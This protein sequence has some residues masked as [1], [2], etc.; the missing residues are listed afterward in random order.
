MTETVE[1]VRHGSIVYTDKWKGYDSLMFC[2]I[3]TSVLIIHTNSSQG[4]CTS[5]ASKD[6]GPLPKNV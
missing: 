2:G 4:K 3:V 6:S 1:K 5:M